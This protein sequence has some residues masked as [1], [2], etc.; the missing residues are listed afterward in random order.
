M[1]AQL[2]DNKPRFD[3]L[4]ARV[5]CIG[6]DNL[7]SAARFRSKHDLPFTLLVDSRRESYKALDIQKGSVRDLI[8]PSVWKGALRSFRAG[9]LQGKIRGNPY[10]LGGAAVI[11]TGGEIVYLHRSENAADNAPIE[12]LIDALREAD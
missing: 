12:E 5:L 7:D 10:Q 8:G 6:M 2:R 3:E 9:N 1:V 11:A 4:G